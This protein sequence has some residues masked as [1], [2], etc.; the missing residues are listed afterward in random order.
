MGKILK[1]YEDIKKDI[2]ICIIWINKKRII[3]ILETII[4]LIFLY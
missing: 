1:S 2:K 3:V 4:F